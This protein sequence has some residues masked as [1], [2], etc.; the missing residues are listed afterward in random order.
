MYK[1]KVYFCIK[2][3]AFDPQGRAVQHAFPSMSYQEVQ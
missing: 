3:S 2:K 1:V